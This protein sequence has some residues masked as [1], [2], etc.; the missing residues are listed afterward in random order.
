MRRN[1]KEL[2]DEEYENA[3]VSEINRD[4]QVCVPNKILFLFRVCVCPDR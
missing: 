1:R 2:N 3:A 4:L